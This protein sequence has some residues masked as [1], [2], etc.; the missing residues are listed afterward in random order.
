MI[1]TQQYEINQL[2]NESIM[3]KS[4]LVK[5]ANQGFKI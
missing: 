5:A 4:R 2:K 1:K 3:L